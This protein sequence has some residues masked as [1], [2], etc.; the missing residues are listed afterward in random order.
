MTR[1]TAPSVPLEL[2][3]HDEATMLA[4][5]R[6]FFET[7]RTRRSV[8]SFAPDP[9]PR[10]LIEYAIA[11]ANTAPSGA[12]RQPWHFA[13]VSDP[14][15]KAEIRRAAEAEERE[16]YEGG[17]ATEEWLAA[18]AFLPPVFLV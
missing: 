8:R 5:A 14:A 17:R 4:Q 18:P 7:M 2:E 6:R 11:A 12:N 15:L 10:E 1:E 9:V 16:F 13:A 3:R